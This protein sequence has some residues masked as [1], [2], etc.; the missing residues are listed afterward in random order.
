MSNPN[1]LFELRQS[2]LLLITA[3][4]WGCSFVAQS[5]GME[6]VGPYTF[7]AS[8]MALG[9]VFL[10]PIVAMLRKRLAASQPDESE[11]RRSPE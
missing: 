5:I 9:F 4:I 8:R 10:L 3:F 2:G 11:R 1:L 6:S 7:T